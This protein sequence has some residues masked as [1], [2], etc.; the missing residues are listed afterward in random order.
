MMNLM[1]ESKFLDILLSNLRKA[2][3]W[4]GVKCT[5]VLYSVDWTQ[6]FLMQSL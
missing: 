3:R 5:E 1:R 6:F 2:R 4:I